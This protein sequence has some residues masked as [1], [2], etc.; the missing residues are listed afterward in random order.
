MELIKW[1]V[2]PI[3]PHDP[4]LRRVHEFYLP[5]RTTPNKPGKVSRLIFQ[6]IFDHGTWFT[7]WFVTRAKTLPQISICRLSRDRWYVSAGWRTHLWSSFISLFEDVFQYTRHI[8]GSLV[9]LTWEKFAFQQTIRNKVENSPKAY[10]EAITRFYSDEYLN[11][12]EKGDDPMRISK[13]LVAILQM[14]DFVSLKF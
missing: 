2:I 12:F 10:R 1:Y 8:S 3:K 11:L 6:Q 7:A 5:H 9:S 14:G 4:Q 13:G